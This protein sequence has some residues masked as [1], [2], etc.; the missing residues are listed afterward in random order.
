M[1]LEEMWSCSDGICP[2]EPV[3]VDDKLHSEQPGSGL[4]MKLVPTKHEFRMLRVD[5]KG[6]FSV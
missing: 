3:E 1:T 6:H 4:D 5:R 2:E